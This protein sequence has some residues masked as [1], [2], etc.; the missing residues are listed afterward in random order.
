[1][2]RVSL[3]IKCIVVLL[4]ASP[5]SYSQDSTKSL[6]KWG[7]GISSSTLFLSTYPSPES[8]NTALSFPICIYSHFKVE[9]YFGFSRSREK[10]K[11]E[12]PVTTTIITGREYQVTTLGIGIFYG[13]PIKRTKLHFGGK[14]GYIISRWENK[15]RYSTS[16]SETEDKGKGYL[17][18]P[19]IGGEY[20]F[21]DHFSLGGEANF[22][23]S[24]LDIDRKERSDSSEQKY[25]LTLKEFRTIGIIYIRIYF[26]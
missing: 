10:S 19:I 14:I 24:S 21:S 7:I 18:S 20:F 11:T 4:S 3:I 2:K 5:F 23:W 12:P 16:L 1:M 6:V 25:S 22:Q 13:K 26:N 9:P 8:N 15:Y 17:F